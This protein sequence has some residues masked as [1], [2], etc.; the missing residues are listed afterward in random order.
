MKMRS[1]AFQVNGLG[2]EKD[3]GAKSDD[4]S[5]PSLESPRQKKREKEGKHTVQHRARRL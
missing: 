3:T 1:T 5:V 2:G 4:F